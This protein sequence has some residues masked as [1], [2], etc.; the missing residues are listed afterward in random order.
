MGLPRSSYVTIDRLGSL[1]PPVAVLPMSGDSVTPEPA[2]CLLAQAQTSLACF[3]L[4]R[5]SSVRMSLTM[6]STLAPPPLTLGM[7]SPL[8]VRMPA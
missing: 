3:Y 2:T 8:T 7:A 5:L 6:L 1:S 4:R